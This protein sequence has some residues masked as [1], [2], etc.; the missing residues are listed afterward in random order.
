MPGESLHKYYLNLCYDFK[1]K[2]ETTRDPSELEERMVTLINASRDLDW[3][4][5]K[6]SKYKKPEAE[7][8]FNHFINELARYTTNLREGH[9]TE[10]QDLL[11]SLDELIL[12]LE[13]RKLE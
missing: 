8:I 9:K 4:E 3:R 5:T 10:T 11:D 6:H 12:L 7:K 13:S 2:I 1:K